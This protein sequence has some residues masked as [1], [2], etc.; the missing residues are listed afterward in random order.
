MLTSFPKGFFQEDISI[1]KWCRHFLQ[2]IIFQ[3]FLSLT[4]S[5]GRSEEEHARSH[6]GRLAPRGP[7]SDEAM[8]PPGW[9]PTPV[10]VL[11]FYK[12][13]KL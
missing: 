4:F 10:M 12:P 6:S 9:C 3:G 7:L 11:G 2:H 13:Q 5:P 1:G 8:V